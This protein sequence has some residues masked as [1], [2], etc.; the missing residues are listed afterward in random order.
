LAIFSFFPV[1]AIIWWRKPGLL[2]NSFHGHR[3]GLAAEESITLIG[4]VSS[5]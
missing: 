3:G 2:A 5:L 4:A 1:P